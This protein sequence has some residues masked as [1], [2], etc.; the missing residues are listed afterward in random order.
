MKTDKEAQRKKI[1][2]RHLSVWQT[3]SPDVWLFWRG[4]A[5]IIR[6]DNKTYWKERQVLLNGKEFHCGRSSLEINQVV[7]TFFFL[8][9]FEDTRLSLVF[10]HA[11]MLLFS[12][13]FQHHWK[14][15]ISAGLYYHTNCKTLSSRETVT[16]SITFSK[17]VFE[18]ITS[19]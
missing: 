5:D 13:G 2:H 12:S 8:L 17:K 16:Q 1:K 11:N 14:A 15:D 7:Y 19:S 6:Q 3:S 18:S 9:S 4:F 10:L